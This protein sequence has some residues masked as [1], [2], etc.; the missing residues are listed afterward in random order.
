MADELGPVQRRLP[1]SGRD[2]YRSIPTAAFAQRLARTGAV[3]HWVILIVSDAFPKLI[4]VISQIHQLVHL[5]AGDGRARQW[6]NLAHVYHLHRSLRQKQDASRVYFPVKP[7]AI[8][9]VMGLLL[10]FGSTDEHPNCRIL[11]LTP[12]A[13][14]HPRALAN[15]TH[16]TAEERHYSH[17]WQPSTSDHGNEAASEGSRCQCQFA[18]PSEQRPDRMMLAW[19]DI[20]PSGIAHRETLSPPKISHSSRPGGT[21]WSRVRAPSCAYATFS[22]QTR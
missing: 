6:D 3:A 8:L 13:Q 14:D 9:W 22:A 18:A 5:V 19:L 17:P 12:K 7:F 2:V 1:S 4:A 10:V 20:R 11:W 15:P 21:V 16:Q